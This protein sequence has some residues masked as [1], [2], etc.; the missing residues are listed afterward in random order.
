MLKQS[1]KMGKN[2]SIAFL[3]L[4]HYSLLILLLLEW[5]AHSYSLTEINNKNVRFGSKL[6]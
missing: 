4:F 6:K 2:Q 3:K 5:T 1:I